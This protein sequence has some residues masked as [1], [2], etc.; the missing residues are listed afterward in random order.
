VL[1]LDFIALFSVAFA[2][3]ALI[4]QQRTNP[5]LMTIAERLAA[6]ENKLDEAASEITTE[7]ITLRGQLG[8]VIT[9]EA[10]ATLARLEGKATALANIIPD[11]PAP[12]AATP[13]QPA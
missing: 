6:I 4:Q 8:N 3:G 13:A 11:A 2:L 10:E 7:L 12:P 5:I 1:I 9:P